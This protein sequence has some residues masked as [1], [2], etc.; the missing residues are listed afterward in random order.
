[1]MGWE[2]EAF[3]QEA[4]D[5]CTNSSGEI[6][7][8]ALFDIQ[9]DDVAA[10]CTFEVPSELE[11]DDIIGPRDG[12]AISIP[13]QSGPAYATTYPVVFAD[14]STQGSNGSTASAAS[15]ST[16][17]SASASETSSTHAIVP[18]L[19]YSAA[20]ASIT[21][22]YGGGIL[23]AETSASYE[24]SSTVT[25]SASVADATGSGSDIVATSYITKGN[26][27][28]EMVVAE[29]D[30]TVTA[31]AVETVAAKHRRHLDQHKNHLTH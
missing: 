15:T 17:S 27:V 5:T 14:G 7:D 22:K 20:T 13:I 8:C 23:V 2:S 1:M 21:D 29:V 16:S 24:A 4:V 3:L 26:E 25:E 19:S 31:T 28:I 11:D 12:L 30:V 6:E 9:S 10:E 18:T